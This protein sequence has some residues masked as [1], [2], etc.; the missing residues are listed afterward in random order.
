MS[1][2]DHAR[3]I[4]REVV[5]QMALSEQPLSP[6]I[7]NAF[8][9]FSHVKAEAFAEPEDLNEAWTDLQ[10]MLKEAECGTNSLERGLDKISD[11]DLRKIAGQI[12]LVAGR[13]A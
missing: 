8:T 6:R 2:K 13:L 4:F 1:A 11:E 12:T 3:G 7:W 10:Q 5:D 9:M